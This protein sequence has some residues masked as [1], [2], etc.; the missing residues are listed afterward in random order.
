MFQ[1]GKTGSRI[2]T[3]RVWMYN[4]CDFLSKNKKLM[5]IL[6]RS[7]PPKPIVITM[8]GDRFQVR[9]TV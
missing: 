2:G 3:L 5:V 7:P 8:Y 6:K 1:R 4:I 9:F